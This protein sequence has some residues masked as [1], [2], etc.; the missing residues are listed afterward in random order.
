MREVERTTVSQTKNSKRGLV[1]LRYQSTR[2]RRLMQE[3]EQALE[4]AAADTSTS[5]ARIAN[6]VLTDPKTHRLWEARH[7]DLLRPVAE[8]KKRNP[9][10][11]ELRRLE[12]Q[13]LHR[14]SLISYVRKHQVTG[15]RR[16]RLFAAFYGPR[17]FTDAVLIEHRQFVLAKSSEVSADHL[18]G[19]MQDTTSRELLSS[20]SSAYANYFSMYC[21]F[22]CAKD[23]DLAS[24]VGTAMKDAQQRVNRLRAA[25]MSV[26]PDRGYAD[27]DQQELIARSGR[28]PALN[29]LNR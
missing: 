12:T 11:F 1:L 6:Q 2:H 14:S 8:Q 17:E 26:K 28:Y 4:D 9:Q 7:A 20:Y 24:A 25:L 21:Y 18:L 15:E 23:S 5:T 13:V 3:S 10:V 22:A 27:F 29:Y 19:I 16:R